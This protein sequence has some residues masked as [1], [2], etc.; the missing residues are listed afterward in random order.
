MYKKTILKKELALITIILFIGMS[1]NSIAGNI[2]SKDYISE[3]VLNLPEPLNYEPEC[4]PFFE[5]HKGKDNWFIND[6]LIY[7]LYVPA[8]VKTIYYKINTED[9]KTYNFEPFYFSTEGS[10]EFEYYWENHHGNATYPPTGEILQLDKTLPTI[11]LK[12]KSGL[13]NKKKLTITANVDDKQEG[14]GINRVEFYF[15]GEHILTDE[16]KPYEYVYEDAEKDHTVTAI[17]HDNAGLNSTD[18]I[19]TEPYSFPYIFI[20]NI[21]QKLLTINPM[22][23]YLI[24]AI[25]QF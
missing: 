4:V 19:I 11:E 3:K 18:N 17:V 10:F 13:F 12:S 16:I 7:F 8:R 25:I 22:F 9:W 24:R 5:G 6:V 23:L 14:S 20:N 15:D 1:T 2:E 21:L